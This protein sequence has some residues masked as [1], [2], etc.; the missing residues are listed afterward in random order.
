MN[1][2]PCSSWVAAEQLSKPAI[3][4]EASQ[5]LDNLNPLGLCEGNL[6]L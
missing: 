3:L 2:G 4:L 5:V 6:L 1:F